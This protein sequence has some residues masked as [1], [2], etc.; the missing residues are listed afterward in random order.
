MNTQLHRAGW[1]VLDQMFSRDAMKARLR[2]GDLG[3]MK[4]SS[5][6]VFF[7]RAQALM[8]MDAGASQELE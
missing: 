2:D 6:G 8:L 1:P 3:M 7:A 4:R 5:F